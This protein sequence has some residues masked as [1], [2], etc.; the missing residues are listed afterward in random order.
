MSGMRNF[1]FCYIAE[2]KP[3]F[4]LAFI[5]ILNKFY[6]IYYLFFPFVNIAYIID[7]KKGNL[8]FLFLS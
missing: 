1:I 2:K 6:F 7:I 4:N 5:T 8:F 3:F